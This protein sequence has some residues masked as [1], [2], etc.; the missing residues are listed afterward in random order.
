[1]AAI[2]NGTRNTCA[3]TDTR[4]YQSGGI[5]RATHTRTRRACR[6]RLIAPWD[7]DGQAQVLISYLF[8]HLIT[9]IG[10]VVVNGRL[11]IIVLSRRL[12]H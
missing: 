2:N 4:D 11:S 8:P 3:Q 7:R 6:V 9:V 12:S 10:R 5:V 1:M